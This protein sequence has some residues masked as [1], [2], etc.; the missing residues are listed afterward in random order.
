M[1]V[2]FGSTTKQKTR[3]AGAAEER[4][5]PTPPLK[6]EHEKIIEQMAALSF[7]FSLFCVLLSPLR[8]G[9]LF[10]RHSHRFFSLSI[11]NVI[12]LALFAFE[13]SLRD[14]L[15]FGGGAACGR[16]RPTSV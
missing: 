11:C 8:M 3:R 10:A 15:P 5:T 9:Y 1:Q 13:R 7:T 12:Y 14:G 16:R 4:E 2:C 6:A